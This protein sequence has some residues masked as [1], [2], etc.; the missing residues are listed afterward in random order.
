MSVV[1]LF[2]T[3]LLSGRR[4]LSVHQAAADKSAAVAAAA[5]TAS[6]SAAATADNAAI[7]AAT[8]DVDSDAARDAYSA[9]S[10]DN[11]LAS[12]K[13]WSVAADATATA[14]NAAAIAAGNAASAAAAAAATTAAA[15]AAA[16]AAAKTD[17]SGDREQKSGNDTGLLM[18][19]AEAFI[20]GR[21][22]Q[23]MPAADSPRCDSKGGRATAWCLL[24]H[25]Q[26]SLSLSLSRGA[27]R[28][29]GAYLYAQ[30]PLAITGA[31]A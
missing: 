31:R 1:S 2:S 27:G 4:I 7:A 30:T 18:P 11:N 16:A 5:A 23:V 9:A 3:T 21:A 6:A 26:V 28:K 12:K 24:T 17:I 13:A 14:A 22:R 25:L 29:P 8:A 15:A 19:C 20:E 10:R